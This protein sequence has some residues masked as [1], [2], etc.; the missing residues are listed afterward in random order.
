MRRSFCVL[1][2]VAAFASACSTTLTQ[3]YAFTATDTESLAVIDYPL[4]TS[5][6]PFRL[7][8]VDFIALDFAR[9]T[10][11]GRIVSLEPAVIG[12]RQ[13]RPALGLDDAALYPLELQ[14]QQ[15]FLVPLELPPGEYA[16]VGGYDI[17]RTVAR[18]TDGS[19]TVSMF[20]TVQILFCVAPVF[21]VSPNTIAV[22]DAPRMLQ[23]AGHNFF[24][25]DPDAGRT[26]RRARVALAAYPQVRGS[27]QVAEQIAVV[28][29]RGDAEDCQSSG[30]FDVVTR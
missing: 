28:R 15:T 9:G 20:T 8:S 10:T 29:F 30:A 16:I 25:P 23:S 2:A 22:V 12:T 14:A 21:R 24:P 7:N 5:D 3:D 4:S 27:V 1:A 6:A 17:P 18:D 13:L 19:V 11:T 26:V